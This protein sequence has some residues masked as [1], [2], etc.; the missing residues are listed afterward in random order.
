MAE[1][2][3]YKYGSTQVNIDPRSEAGMAMKDLRNSIK[4]AHL[5]GDGYEEQPHI[6]VRYG[7]QDGNLDG[8]KTFLSMQKPFTIAFGSTS[9][10]PPSESSDGA[11]PVFVDVL[12]PELVRMNRALAD[13]GNFKPADFPYNPHATLAYVDERYASLYTDEDDL[14][15]MIYKVH[16]IAITD[17]NGNQHEVKLEVVDPTYALAVSK[18]R[19]RNPSLTGSA[20]KAYATAQMRH[21]VTQK[22]FLELLTEEFI[23]NLEDAIVARAKIGGTPSKESSDLAT[24]ISEQLAVFPYDCPE[25]LQIRPLLRV[26]ARL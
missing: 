14:E 5:A 2:F 10:F 8:I 23:R 19:E 22:P 11:A 21:D 4:K 1:E 12:S 26:L 7:I 16:S 13:V 9:S 20:L 3:K 24:V 18:V 25:C 6:T 17:R 15:G